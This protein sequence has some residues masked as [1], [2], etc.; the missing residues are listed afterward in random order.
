MESRYGITIAGT[1]AYAPSN[2][3]TNHDLEQRVDTSDEWIRTRTGICE[4][5]IAAD[6]EPTS[7]M[8]FEA[9]ARALDAAGMDAD[10]LDLIIV[11]TLSPDT[12]M[13]NTACH[14][15]RRLKA[16]RAAC[17]SLEAACTGF[18]Y[19]LQAGADMIRAGTFSNA[20]IVGAEKLSAYT[21]WEDRNTCVLFGDGAGAAVLKRAPADG[22]ALLGGFLAADGNYTDLLIIPGGGSLAPAA[23]NEQGERTNFIQMAGREVFKLAVNIMA[24][25]CEKALAK[26]GCSIDDVRWLIPHQ[27]NIRIIKGVGRRLGLEDERVAVNVD[28]YGNTSAATIPLM[29]DELVRGDQVKKGDLLLLTAFG[30]GITWG[31]QLIRW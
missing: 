24:E 3:I 27:A 12:V 14:L 26:S 4:R 13:P 28:R 22:D 7:A 16:T 19:G 23:R 15:Q 11:A 29:L 25:A 30:G 2:V 1:G 10:E 17:F 21:N 6:D 9:A 5:H 31:A 8:A 18:L 20:L